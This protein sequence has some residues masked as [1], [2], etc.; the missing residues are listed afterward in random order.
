M[1]KKVNGY[2]I[3]E[4]VYLIPIVLLLYFLVIVS[5]F[6]LYDRCVISQDGYLLAFRAGHFSDSAENYGEIIYADMPEEIDESYIRDRFSDRSKVYPYLREGELKVKVQNEEVIVTVSGFRRLLSVNKSVLR[7]NPI[8]IIRDVRR[9]N[10]GS[11]I[12]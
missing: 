12:P 9:K 8:K 4:A 7:Q 2:F 6:Y 1:Y 10:H 11:E 5:G 3:V